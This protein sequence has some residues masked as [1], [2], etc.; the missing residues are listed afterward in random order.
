MVRDYTA[1]QDVPD[2]QIHSIQRM[3]RQVQQKRYCTFTYL[4]A[5]NPTR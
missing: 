5:E 3:L 2:I 1:R 4:L